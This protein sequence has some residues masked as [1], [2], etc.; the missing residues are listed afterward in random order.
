M[1][2]SSLLARA[3]NALLDWRY[4]IDTRGIFDVG[5]ST[6]YEHASTNDYWLL[7]RTIAR[8]DPHSDD[9][10]MDIGCGLGRPLAVAAR[11]PFRYCVG[12]EQDPV[13]AARCK[14]NFAD[15]PKVIVAQGNAESFHYTHVNALFLHNPFKASV[16]DT[17]LARI[18]RTRN[19][20][21]KLVWMQ[22]N[23]THRAVFQRY[24]WDLIDNRADAE[25]VPIGLYVKS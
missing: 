7:K 17:V 13:I 19:R 15:Q 2:H 18:E 9:V 12:L 20:P 5:G 1:R 24:G 8:L 4:G 14:A 3:H 22:I 16:L 6:S 23:N 21:L 25:D 11:M 10:F